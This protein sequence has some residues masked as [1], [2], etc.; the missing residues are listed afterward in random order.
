[1]GP[2]VRATLVREVP[3]LDKRAERPAAGPPDLGPVDPVGPA[4]RSRFGAETLDRAARPALRDSLHEL[5]D[6]FDFHALV[7]APADQIVP[8][9]VG[10][11]WLLLT[12]FM[13][14]ARV[15]HRLPCAT[16]TAR[17]CVPG[18]APVAIDGAFDMLTV[19]CDS[20]ILELYWRGSF[21]VPSDAAEGLLVQV[22]R[23]GGGELS[24]RPP[25]GN[26]AS[27][28]ALGRTELPP[29]V[30][31]PAPN[32]PSSAPAAAA[33]GASQTVV[34]PRRR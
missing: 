25:P 14:S 19:D 15:E 1:V 17:W 32:P 10:D 12:G 30:R 24:E 5:P 29:I 22:L 26:A 2:L 33:G 20:G 3:V 9:L 28:V 7:V 31:P 16:L 27:E 23:S 21:A 6:T 13:G 4:A 18:Q 8:R 11:E 34:F